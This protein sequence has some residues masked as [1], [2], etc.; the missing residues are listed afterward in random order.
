MELTWERVF[1]WRM[2]RQLLDRPAPGG[3][4]VAVV[5]R[6][7]GVQAQVASYAELAVAARQAEPAKGDVPAAVKGRKLVKTWA[8][9]GTLHLLAAQDAPA[10]LSLLATT[11][12]W[13]RPIWQRGFVTTEQLA[14]IAEAA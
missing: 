4:A 13:E 8:M 9:R 1:A 5:R 12:S 10:Y 2:R 6:L 14:A 11:K 3:G 7:C